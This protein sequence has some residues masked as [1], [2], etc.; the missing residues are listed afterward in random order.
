MKYTHKASI[1]GQ[2]TRIIGRER[3]DSINSVGANRSGFR[4]DTRKGRRFVWFFLRP[5]SLVRGLV[6]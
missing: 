1:I 6:G 4:V 5:F 2:G 3:K